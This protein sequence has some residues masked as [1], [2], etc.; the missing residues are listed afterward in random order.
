MTS[1]SAA[2]QRLVD[3]G[4]S[5]YEAQAYVGLLGREP[6]TGYALSNATGIPQPKVYEALRR[7]AAKEVVAPLPGEPARFVAVPADRVLSGLE[8]SFAERLSSAQRE[9]AR[10]AGR[11]DGAD[12]RV[13]R[14][15]SRWPDIERHAARVIDEA[16]RHVYVSVNCPQTEAIAAAAARADD[17]GVICDV[18]H[19]GEPIVKL[20][21]GRTVGHDSTRG[22]LYRRHQARHVAVVADSARVVWALAPDGAHWQ[23]IAGDDELLGALAKGY[24]RHDIYVQQIWDEFHDVLAERFGPGMQQLVGELSATPAG[25]AAGAGSGHRRAR[26]GAVSGPR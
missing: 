13:L 10:A 24:I 23:C 6:M 19:F 9:L 14:S 17:R 22:V 7:L 5:Q 12:F 18:L 4:F 15:F 8:A 11:A 26:R 16:L 1:Q 25:R 3:L 2:V 21:H 20:R